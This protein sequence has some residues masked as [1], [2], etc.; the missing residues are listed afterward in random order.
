[1]L[2]TVYNHCT[3]S[4]AKSAVSGSQALSS[5]PSINQTRIN[6]TQVSNLSKQR[7]MPNSSQNEGAQII[8]CELYLKLQNFLELYLER[9]QQVDI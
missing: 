6:Q 4:S 3:S 1:M 5:S 2:R 7:R 8:G 9:L